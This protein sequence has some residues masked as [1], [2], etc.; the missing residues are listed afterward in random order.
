MENDKRSEDPNKRI[1][2]NEDLIN[3]LTVLLFLALLSFFSLLIANGIIFL[4]E[5]HQG[6]TIA[7]AMKQLEQDQSAGL[8]NYIRLALVTNHVFVFIFPALITAWFI[9]KKEWTVFIKLHFK[10][11]PVQAMNSLLGACML[12]MAFPIAQLALWLNQQL[13]LPEWA[14]SI[15]SNANAMLQNLLRVES[16]YELVLN[17][18][19]VAMIPAIGE[20]LLFRGILQRNFE[21]LFKNPHTAI[22]LAAV[23]FSAFHF[24]FEGF[25]P[26]VLLG[27]MLGYFY[28]FSGS[29][30]VPVIAHFFY[31]G[32]QI[33]AIYFYTNNISSFDIDHI[34][35]LPLGLIIFSFIFVSATGFYFIRFNTKN[36]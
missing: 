28:Y 34:D 11:L 18:V 29:L 1:L 2:S 10:P 9:F 19:V 35:H 26:R 31:N 36:E 22:W 20:E 5:Y 30:W 17:I 25:L 3:P 8:R 7:E 32:F 21:N 15:E 13:S 14:K 23:I 4:L 33:L 6:L 27:A 16:P 12:I 24:Q